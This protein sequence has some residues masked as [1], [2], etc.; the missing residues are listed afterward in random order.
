M[1]VSI[2]VLLLVALALLCLTGPS[3]AQPAPSPPG[4]A[5]MA[6]EVK[7]NP[8]LI[9][10]LG[11]VLDS[12]RKVAATPVVRRGT[13]VDI[14]RTARARRPRKFMDGQPRRSGLTGDVGLR[15]QRD[16]LSE[17]PRWRLRIAALAG[18]P[19]RRVIAQLEETPTWSHPQRPGWQ[20]ARPRRTGA[21]DY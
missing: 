4:W 15:D 9:A 16:D 13:T 5:A 11:A 20:L 1:P 17:L 10:P 21:D 8:E 14:G 6:D 18:G 2:A 12:A 7:A 19:P 3:G